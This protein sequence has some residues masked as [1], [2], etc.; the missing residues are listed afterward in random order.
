M[1]KLV[2]ISTCIFSLSIFR[3]DTIQAQSETSC[4]SYH[5]LWSPTIAD[6]F[7][8]NFTNSCNQTMEI[9][10]YCQTNGGDWKPGQIVTVKPGTST[11]WYPNYGYA[12]G[13]GLT[14]KI[15]YAARV[16]GDSNSKF[17]TAE[18]MNKN[19]CQH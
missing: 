8:I 7:N 11:E 18:E 4:I 3:N 9:Q 1:K 10:W 16:A 5:T 15:C 19:G 14:G 13:S 6:M 12:G 17:P 2:L